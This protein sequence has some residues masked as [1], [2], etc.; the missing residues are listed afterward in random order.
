ME[1]LQ[2][3]SLD[4]TCC[5]QSLF[6]GPQC[7]FLLLDVCLF[8]FLYLE[9]H[10]WHPCHSPGHPSTL[11]FQSCC[12]WPFL[13]TSGRV[14]YSTLCS[15]S[16]LII[17]FTT[18]LWLQSWSCRNMGNL[19]EST[20][21]SPP[22]W[23]VWESSKR[24]SEVSTKQEGVSCSHHVAFTEGSLSGPGSLLSPGPI[25]WVEEPPPRVTTQ[26]DTS[27]LRLTLNQTRWKEL[28]TCKPI[29]PT[30]LTLL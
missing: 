9:C 22:L 5:H 30:T 8:H 18:Q 21:N 24:A 12:I 26:E 23:D 10:P 13:M 20:T 16:S 2:P 1:L 4:S 6:P 28:P 7:P 27:V 17:Y 14:I 11:A 3:L 15:H 29:L 25:K 19:S